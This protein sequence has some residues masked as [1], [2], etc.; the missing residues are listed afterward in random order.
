MNDESEMPQIQG[1]KSLFI[2][3]HS[4]LIISSPLDTL[5]D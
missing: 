5:N 2:T 4:A 3:H 1:F